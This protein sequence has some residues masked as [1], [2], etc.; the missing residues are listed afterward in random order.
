[1]LQYDQLEIEKQ[2]LEFWEKGR[3]PQ[4]LAEQRKGGKPLKKAEKEEKRGDSPF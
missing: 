3:I 2:I 4:R 1:M